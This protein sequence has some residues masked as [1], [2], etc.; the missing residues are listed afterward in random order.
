VS[1]DISVETFAPKQLSE[2]EEALVQGVA[3]YYHMND[4]MAFGRGRAIGWM[5]I[6]EPA[7]QSAN[8]IC[9]TVGCERA[10]IDYVADLL[11][12]PGVL[13]RSPAPDPDD[14]LLRMDDSAWPNRMQVVFAN[15]PNFHRIMQHGVEVL[16]DA[17]EERRQR[18]VNMERLFRY[19]SAEIPTILDGWNEKERLA[20]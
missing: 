2:A 7:V 16:A 20:G 17:P 3:D 18:V 5:I 8:Q 10:E 12:P 19:L 13:V 15:I 9:A 6:A 1:H 14:Y 4:G 11:V